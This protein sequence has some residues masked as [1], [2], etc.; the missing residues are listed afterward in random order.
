M[1][2]YEPLTDIIQRYASL[3]YE[4]LRVTALLDAGLVQ[5]DPINIDNILAWA[6]IASSIG[7]VP[8]RSDAQ[9]YFLPV[10]LKLLWSQPGSDLPL[11][12]STV[13]EP[14]GQQYQ[15]VAYTHRRTINTRFIADVKGKPFNPNPKLGRY[16][17]TRTP[18]PEKLAEAWTA[19]LMGNYDAVAELLQH[20]HH[21]GKRRAEGKG[22]V[23]EW[24]IERISEFRLVD[25]Q[26]QLRRMVPVEYLVS[27]G[28]E[29][30]LNSV[31]M[32]AQHMG[33][34]P[35][36]W[37]GIPAIRTLCIPDGTRIRKREDL[38]C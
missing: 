23:R 5:Y 36:Y 30:D 28:Y 12:A 29:P 14:V 35:P 2:Y 37:T 11:W 15:A 4:P 10:P 38:K 32:I 13:L 3:D 1:I 8:E 21:I 16:K 22:L 6:A 9:P 26:S 20:V 17:E 24:R 7:R 25:S 19:D 31:G 18:H 27:Q 34:T 33:W